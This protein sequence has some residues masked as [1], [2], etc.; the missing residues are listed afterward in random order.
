MRRLGA[1]FSYMAPLADRKPVQQACPALL[2]PPPL[3]L[4]IKLRVLQSTPGDST[5]AMP[6]PNLDRVER[7]R[8]LK[9]LYKKL[10]ALYPGIDPR[11][12]IASQMPNARPGQLGQHPNQAMMKTQQ[13]GQMAGSNHSS[14]A[15]GLQA[16]KT[17]QMAN[18]AA[19]MMHAQP[20]AS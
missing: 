20:T 18:A 15:P 2:T 19:P 7:D 12:E 8:I 6:D 16:H 17:P 14:P 3:N 10:Q 5:E 9:D 11:K 13:N 4:N 1:N